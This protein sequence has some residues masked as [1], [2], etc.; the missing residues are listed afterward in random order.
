MRNSVGRNRGWLMGAA[1]AFD[2]PP[3]RPV[4]AARALEEDRPFLA[5]DPILVP[6]QHD[7]VEPIPHTDRPVKTAM[8]RTEW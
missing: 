7:T 6:E 8:A 1:V 2:I 4:A 5:A 3:V